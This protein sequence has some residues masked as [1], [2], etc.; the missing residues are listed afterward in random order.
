MGDAV[1]FFASYGYRVSESQYAVAV[2]D[3]PIGPFQLVTEKV[4]TLA[5]ENTGELNLF[6][7]DNG[8]AYAIYNAHI[9]E[10]VYHPDHLMSIEKLSAAYLSSL[11]KEFNSGYLGQT[12]VEGGAMFK[13]NGIYYAIFGQCYCYCADGS[14]VTIYNSTY[15]LGPYGTMN[16]IGNKGYAQ[17][18]ST[19]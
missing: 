6:Q 4:T 1:Q 15:P 14:G 12:F 17:H 11:G 16:S 18:S 7:D 8:D 13:R 5:W 9:D 3:T 2:S 10:G 19:F